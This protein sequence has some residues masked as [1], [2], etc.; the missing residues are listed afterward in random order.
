MQE[1][2][3]NALQWIFVCKNIWKDT[4]VFVQ[5]KPFHT[6][7]AFE[8]LIAHAR[9]SSRSKLRFFC[10]KGCRLAATSGQCCQFAAGTF[11]TSKCLLYSKQ[12]SWAKI[13]TWHRLVDIDSQRVPGSLC[14][15]LLNERFVS[16]IQRSLVHLKS[17]TPKPSQTCGFHNFILTLF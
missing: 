12:T 3:F 15:L 1:I 4:L 16:A 2:Q 10:W 17:W 14:K 5:L 7:L 8:K 6:N 13:G 9:G 11:W